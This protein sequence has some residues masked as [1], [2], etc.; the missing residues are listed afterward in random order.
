MT[1]HVALF[2]GGMDSAVATHKVASDGTV[3]LVAYLDTGVGCEQNREYV[4]RVADEY[5]WHLWTLRTP[6]NYRELVER[7]GFPGPSKHNW[8]YRYLKERQLGKLATV[9]DDLH[10]WT[11]VRSKESANRMATVEPVQEAGRWTWHAPIHDWSKADCREYVDAHS[12]PENPLWALLGRSGD[13]WC[14]AYANRMELID[15]EACGCNG[16]VGDIRGIEEELDRAD[17]RDEWAWHDDDPSAWAMEDDAQM[18]LCSN[19]GGPD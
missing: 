5:G 10:L 4:E 7:Y 9:A 8:F 6:K 16:V 2:S 19:C 13:C 17:G 3:D 15:G 1:T 11:G 12:V 18:T 14:G